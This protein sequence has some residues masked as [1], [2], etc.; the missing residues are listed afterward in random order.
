MPSAEQP[1]RA[2]IRREARK[3]KMRVQH[4]DVLH[5]PCSRSQLAC[6]LDIYLSIYLV[7]ER[8]RE[9]ER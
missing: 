7:G 1:A 8:G 9:G 4:S 3:V 5:A 6:S 2:K